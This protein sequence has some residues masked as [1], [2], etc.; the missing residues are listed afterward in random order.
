[1][2]QRSKL[3][4]LPLVSRHE[5]GTKGVKQHFPHDPVHSPL[6][7]FIALTIWLTHPSLSNISSYCFCLQWVIATAMVMIGSHDC[8]WVKC[9]G[10][11]LVSIFVILCLCVLIILLLWSSCP[12]HSY[13]WVTFNVV[14]MISFPALSIGQSYSLGYHFVRKKK[15]PWSIPFICFG[16]HV[17]WLLFCSHLWPWVNCTGYHFVPRLGCPVLPIQ[18]SEISF[19]QSTRSFKYRPTGSQPLHYLNHFG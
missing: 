9:T 18:R 11:H 16:Y 14:V 3:M 13:L 10:C 17:F 15:V 7:Q 4:V 5:F 12:S 19:D 8:P 2:W 1:M 6:C